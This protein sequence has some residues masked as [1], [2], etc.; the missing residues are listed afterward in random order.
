MK[1]EKH[2]E[3]SPMYPNHELLIKFVH[4]VTGYVK[5][6]KALLSSME[7][8]DFDLYGVFL[9]LLLKIHLWRP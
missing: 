4:C 5:K 2:F 9:R 1:Y 8:T 3:S 7:S 6:T